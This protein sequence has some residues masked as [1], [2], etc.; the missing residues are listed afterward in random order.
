MR[1]L[2]ACAAVVLVACP[3]PAPTPDAGADAGAQVTIVELCE[4]LSAA[5]CA[6][7]VRCYPAFLRL[8]PDDC[9]TIENSTCL[10]EYEAI[11]SS[12]FRV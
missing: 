2:L 3:G 12:F 1:S 11:R 6:L 4:R 7:K 9:R 10:A 8:T 5:R